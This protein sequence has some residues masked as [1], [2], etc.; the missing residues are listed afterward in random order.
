ADEKRR[1]ELLDRKADGVRGFRKSFVPKGA[2]LGFPS[3]GGEQ[4]GLGA[5][6]ECAHG[7]DPHVCGVLPIRVV[8]PGQNYSGWCS[9]PSCS[10]HQRKLFAASPASCSVAAASSRRRI[11]SR[12]LGRRT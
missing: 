8:L 6:V 4:L 7:D 3:P 11:K 10:T 12:I 5:V 2:R 1:R 9:S